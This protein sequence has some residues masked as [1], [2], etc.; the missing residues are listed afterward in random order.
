MRF[1]A[2]LSFLAFLACSQKPQPA[3]HVAAPRPAPADAGPAQ[4]AAVT[5]QGADISWL[6]GTWE[7]QSAL[8][9][10]LLFNAPREVAILAGSPPAMVDRGEFIPNGKEISLFLKRGTQAGIVERVLLASPDRSELHERGAAGGTY[11]RGAP[12]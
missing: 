2:A 9:E 3:A 8:K 6:V 4:E 12:P 10:W 5:G 1:A 11:R 7:R